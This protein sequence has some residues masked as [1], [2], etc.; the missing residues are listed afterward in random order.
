M[1]NVSRS[2]LTNHT[3]LQYYLH[4]SITV[5]LPSNVTVQNDNAQNDRINS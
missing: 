5:D 1:V 4:V 2:E 3:I